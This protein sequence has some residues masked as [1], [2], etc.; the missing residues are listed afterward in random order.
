MFKVS[1]RDPVPFSSYELLKFA[2]NGSFRACEAEQGNADDVAQGFV[3]SVLSISKY[4]IL[5]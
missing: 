4:G 3:G 5:S 2:K 1:N